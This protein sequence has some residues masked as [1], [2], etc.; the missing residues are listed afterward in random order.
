MRVSRPLVLI[1]K[2]KPGQ[3]P[4]DPSQIDFTIDSPYLDLAEL[5]APTPGGPHGRQQRLGEPHRSK[6]VRA[7][8]LLPDLERHVL[9][10]SDG[11]DPGAAIEQLVKA[12]VASL[13]APA[14]DRPAA[15]RKR[16]PVPAN[17]GLAAR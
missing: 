3:K 17:A 12:T 7:E 16:S 15:S 8:Q 13:Q 11:G 5:V 9:D 6:Q 4:P 10:A 14:V 2:T 1:A